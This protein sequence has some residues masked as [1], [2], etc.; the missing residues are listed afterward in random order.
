MVF[1]DTTVNVDGLSNDDQT[2]VILNYTKIG[3]LFEVDISNLTNP[4]SIGDTYKI[5]NH[6]TL[7]LLDTH[8]LNNSLINAEHVYCGASGVNKDWSGCNVYSKSFDYDDFTIEQVIIGSV[9]QGVTTT[10]LQNGSHH[11]WD[12]AS[13]VTIKIDY[14]S[15]TS[16]TL[17]SL[18]TG[19]NYCIIG[20]EILQFAVALDNL[21]GTFTISTLLRGRRGTE[22]Y[23]HTH[24]YLNTMMTN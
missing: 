22:S 16:Y 21:D 9:V 13:T 20:T 10:I 2:A 18:L 3:G 8:T 14:G 11:L 15:L 4:I 7:A 24:T 1:V 17:E 12:K 6:T 5:F 23:T 19:N